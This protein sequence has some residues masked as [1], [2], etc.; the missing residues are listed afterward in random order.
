MDI[1]AKIEIDIVLPNTPKMTLFQQLNE[2]LIM[3]FRSSF[4]TLTCITN[5]MT[6]TEYETTRHRFVALKPTEKSWYLLAPGRHLAMV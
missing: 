1:K 2:S 6:A 4:E 5:M 3:L